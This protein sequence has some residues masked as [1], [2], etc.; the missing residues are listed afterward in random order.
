MWKSVNVENYPQAGI[1]NVNTNSYM[2]SRAS[3]L[4]NLIVKG[5]TELRQSSF[6]N[7]AAKNWNNAPI[8]IT[9]SKS[10]SNA[11]REIKIFVQT[12]LL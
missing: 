1:H 6:V 7:D 12:L 8:N 5:K 9:Q 3:T 10:L 4:G 2:S 11:K